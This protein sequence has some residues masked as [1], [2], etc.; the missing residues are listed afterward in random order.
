LFCQYPVVFAQPNDGGFAETMVV[1]SNDDG[2]A[3]TM[4]VFRTRHA[5]SLRLAVLTERW[6]FWPNDGGFGRTMA[7]MTLPFFFT[8]RVGGQSPTKRSDKEA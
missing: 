6:P 8:W 7:V 5:V 4:A 3:E 1:W 2:F